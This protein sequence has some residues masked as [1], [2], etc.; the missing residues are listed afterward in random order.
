MLRL[1]VSGVVVGSAAVALVGDSSLR[2]FILQRIDWRTTRRV[3]EGFELSYW[4]DAFNPPV[5]RELNARL[6][7][8][9]EVD[10]LNQKTNAVT[11]QELQSLGA[12]RA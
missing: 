3:G 6:P 12:L 11:F 4:Y 10:F 8:G 9:A 1:V 7:H 2:A 5:I